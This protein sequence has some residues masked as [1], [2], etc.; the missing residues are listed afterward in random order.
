MVKIFVGGLSTSV[1]SE[2]LRER[3]EKYGK[4]N[5]CDVLK[6]YAFV[7]MEREDE[8]NKAISGLHK[9]DLKGSTLTVEYAT[10][11]IR[12]ATKIYV[13]NVSSKATSSDIR[14]LFEEYGRV[15][16]CDIVKNYAFVHMAM[17]RDAMD[18]IM[19]LNDRTVEGQKIFVTLS[20]SNNAQK[21]GKGGPM[22]PPSPPPPPPSYFFRQRLPPPPPPPSY[23]SRSLYDR[24]YLER[25][26][27][28]LYDRATRSVYDRAYASSPSA[29]EAAAMS[30]LMPSSYRERSPI[31]R[32]SGSLSQYSD[33]YSIS[34]GYGQGYG[35]GYASA[36]SHYSVGAGYSAEDYYERYSN[37]YASHSY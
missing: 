37:G 2:D 32:R 5:E 3:F 28:D 10:S 16:E 15:L 19:N 23:S 31:S 18:A 27:Y 12:N 29:I 4:V 30:A 1:T 36:L 8:A 9:K 11:K 14:A 35:Q 33:P 13:G 26:A 17:E 6:N 7:H 22:P 24:D 21:G 20:K 34:Q 25:Y